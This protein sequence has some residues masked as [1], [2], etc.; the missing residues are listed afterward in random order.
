M[1]SLSIMR[2]DEGCFAFCP[3]LVRE[4]GK[5]FCFCSISC[6][7]TLFCPNDDLTT[8][9]SAS[10]TPQL[11]HWPGDAPLRLSRQKWFSWTYLQCRK[12]AKAGEI[13]QARLTNS[14]HCF[15]DTVWLLQVAIVSPLGMLSSDWFRGLYHVS[16]RSTSLATSHRIRLR[17][18]M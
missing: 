4:I 11:S 8:T 14:R 18:R 6:F 12:T 16:M 10:T 15:S 7:P 3:E 2:S 5:S 9:V 13:S 17:L 1:S